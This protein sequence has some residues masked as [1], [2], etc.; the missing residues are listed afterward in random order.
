M[1]TG[2][3][4]PKMFTVF[5]PILS[6]A[7]ISFVQISRESID[8]LKDYFRDEM[9]KTDWQLIIEMKKTFEII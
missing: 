3:C 4:I 7:F 1:K 9:S 2:Q 8:A 5:S 6:T